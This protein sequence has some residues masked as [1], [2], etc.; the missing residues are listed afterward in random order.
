MKV[1]LLQDVKKLGNKGDVVNVNDGYARNFLLPRNLASEATQEAMNVLKQEKKAQAKKEQEELEAAQQLEKE[2]KN[3]KVT[4]AVKAG[5][6]GRLFGS[7]SNKDIAK[8][9]A[10]Q[11][12]YKIDRRK[13]L[14]EEPI[15]ILG[16]Q[17]VPIK[18]HSNVTAH[19]TVQVT[20]A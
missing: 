2:L 1:I 15:R 13:I 11:L 6:G 10:S 14:L 8:A 17:Q 19:L 3:K 5:E 7:V 18:I 9:I 20:E 4:I 16:S 12:K